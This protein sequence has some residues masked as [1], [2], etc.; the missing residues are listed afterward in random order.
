MNLLSRA[1]EA[2]IRSSLRRAARQLATA[3]SETLSAGTPERVLR[4]FH[5]AA[6]S[7]P[8]YRRLLE[9]EGI[10]A[11]KVD[12]LE[13]FHKQ[14]PIIDKRSWFGNKLQEICTGGNLEGIATFYS[15]SGQTGFFSYGVETRQEQKNAA[16][17]VE[18]ALQQA[19]GALDRKTL[20]INCLP[21][22]V[23]L[24]TR[25]LPVA[26]TSV[27]EDV[28]WSL[29]RKLEGQFEQYV[30]IG[31]HPFLK[32]LV[33]GGQEGPNRIDWAKLRVHAVTGGEF[34]AENFRSYLASLL[35]MDLGNPNS[36]KIVINYGLS[37]LS[38]SIAQENWHTIQ[39]RR[40]AHR[41]S[42][43]R[44]ALCCHESAFCP[45]VMQ[46]Y[47]SQVYLESELSPQNRE[48]LVV[49]MLDEHRRIPI[50]RYNT[51]DHAR[52]ISHSAIA[53][54]L[55]DFGQANLIPP[56]C[57]PLVLMWG[58]G[59]G[60]WSGSGRAIGS[61]LIKEALYE[62]PRVATTITGNF[63]LREAQSGPEVL[64]QL[65][66]TLE[67]SEE[68]HER[69]CRQLIRFAGTA[70]AAELLTYGNF[71]FGIRHDFERKNRYLD[72]ENP[73]AGRTNPSH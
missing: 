36:G 40:L 41:D 11:A 53:Q 52:L 59:E 48:E 10:A 13:A 57:L 8:A 37:E 28:I 38:V 17:S 50:I 47:P 22:G 3:D 60:M 31:E 14:V 67:P 62:D 26:D 73:G 46:Y 34:V 72:P 30:L 23:R 56:T 35:G 55:R 68:I 32:H 33:E 42:Q 2:L 16:L 1:R 64:V 44:E 70:I 39:I 27:R 29:L 66:E 19:F 51:R 5:S 25:S 9:Q 63:R 49:T 6:A 45:V 54:L 71:P 43:F 58:K 24:H 15:S 65:R 21:M 7:V 18:F 69:L 4:I 20:L 61:E 12:S